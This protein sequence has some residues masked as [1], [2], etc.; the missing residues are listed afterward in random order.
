[1]HG[2]LPSFKPSMQW[3][4]GARGTKS[5]YSAD[6]WAEHQGIPS[7]ALLLPCQVGLQEVF[8]QQPV[9]PTC[10]PSPFQMQIPML[11]QDG[12]SWMGSAL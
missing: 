8:V 1:M 6:A 10:L 12:A 7:A 2:A 11:Q 4:R 5:Q 3:G 9:P